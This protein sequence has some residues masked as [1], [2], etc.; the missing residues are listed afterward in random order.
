MK[1][2]KE[3]KNKEGS[4]GKFL[5]LPFFCLKNIMSARG[6]LQSTYCAL[7]RI[8]PGKWGF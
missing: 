4:I 7:Q 5:F 6:N 8:R 3:E 1:Q 2:N